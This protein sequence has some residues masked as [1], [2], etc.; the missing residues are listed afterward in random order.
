MLVITGNPGVGKHTISKI[1]AKKLSLDLIDI[2]AIAIK[3]NTI[4]SKDSSGYVVDLQKL[5]LLL[6]KYM[7]KKS[8]IVGHLAP[9]VLQRNDVCM[10]AVIR[11][12]PYELESVYKKRCYNFQKITDNLSGEIIGICLYDTIKKFGKNKVAEFDNTAVKSKV[13]TDKIIN[14]FKGNVKYIVGKIDW[15]SLISANN[16]MYKFFEYKKKS[17]K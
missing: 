6:K 8:L 13:T 14:Y 11:R 2:N 5:S 12:S 4:K 10:V 17:K 3:N 7:N 9:Y 1:V 15:L 16:D